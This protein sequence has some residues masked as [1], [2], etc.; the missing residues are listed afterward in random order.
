M[1]NPLVVQPDAAPSGFVNAGTGDNGWMTGISIAES[2][3]D[4]FN[5]IKDGNWVEGGLG[6][7][8]LVADA[9]S[10]A[11]D[12]FGTLLSSAASFLMEHMQPLKEALDWLAG[13]PPVIESYSATWNKV[14]EELGKI[15][16]DYQ[17]AVQQGTAQW[18][19]AAADAYR[20]A[21]GAQ[22]DALAGAASTAGSVGT[23]VGVMGM[24]V[25]FVREM[26]RDLIADLVAKLITWVL[27]AVFTLG[28]GTPVIVAQ[29]VTAISKWATRIGELIQ[30]L[31]KTIKKVSPLLGKI[32]E[33]FTK[34]MKVVGKLV[35]KVTG[36]DV[37]STKSIKPGGLFHRTDAPDLSPSGGRGTPSSPDSSSSTPDSSPTSSSSS[38]SPSSPDGSSPTSPSTGSSPSSP[39]SSSSPPPA[40]S[41]PSP[42]PSSNG[43]SPSSSPSPDGPGSPNAP[44]PGSPSSP[45]AGSPS[46]GGPAGGPPPGG[47]SAPSANGPGSTPDAPA[48]PR[49]TGQTSQAGVT[50]P[51]APTQHAPSAPRDGGP[52]AGSPTTAQQGPTGGPAGTPG[53]GAPG[54]PPAAGGARPGAGGGWTGT[55]GSRGD[56]GSGMPS[57]RTPDVSPSPAR[58]SAPSQPGFGPSGSPN[59][60]SAPHSPNAP[61]GGPSGPGAPHSPSGPSAPNAPHGGPGAPHGPGGGAPHSPDGP[62]GP[63]TTSPAGR[64]DAPTRPQ[65]TTSPTHADGPSAPHTSPNAPNAPG[66]PHVPQQPGFTPSPGG[67]GAPHAGGPGS[68]APGGHGP[69]GRPDAPGHRPDG[70]GSRPDGRPDASRPRTDAPGGHPGGPSRPDPVHH[71]PDADGAR[72][73]GAESPTTHPGQR[74]DAPGQPHHRPDGPDADGRTDGDTPNSPNAHA[75]ER[76][77]PEQAHERHAERTPAGVS[78]HGGDPDM[79][80]LPHRVPDDPRFFTADVH[81]TPDGRAR[82]GGH[83]YTPAEY[84]DMLRRSGYDGS[85]PVRLIGCDA[86]GNDF[87][88]QLS[89]H[90]D[91]PVVAPNRPAWTD[92][93]GRVFASDA[94]IGPDGTRSP[95][96]P[97][98]GEWETHHPDGSRT[99]AGEDGYAPGSDRNTDGDG[100]RDRGDSDGQENSD[101]PENQ[102]APRRPDPEHTPIPKDRVIRPDD[103]TYNDR[104]VEYDRPTHQPVDPDNP[105]APPRP[106]NRN[107]EIYAPHRDRETVPDGNTQPD[108]LQPVEAPDTVPAPLRD[109]QP[110]RPWTEYPVRNENGTRTTFI[111]DGDGKVKWVEATPGRQDMSIDGKG[112]WSGFNPDLSHPLLPDVQYQV[113]NTHNPDKVLSFHTNEHGQTDAMTG[114]VEAKGQN[115]DYRDDDSGKGAQQRAYQEGEAAYPSNPP[116]R[117]LTPQELENSRVKWAGGHLLANELGGLGEY[118]NMHPQMAASN[119]GNIRDGWVH[120]ASW[121]E[122]ENYLVEFAS[123]EHQDV[124]NYQVRATRGADGVPDE[125]TMRWQEVTYEVDANGKPKLDADGNKIVENVVTKERVFPNRPEVNYGPTNRYAKR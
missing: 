95:R 20:A 47:P 72:P 4:T 19:G 66:S 8:G 59:A 10:M 60:P 38:P 26:V 49:N 41:G 78:H 91:A 99:R 105:D 73:R 45:S 36:L 14:S 121:R 89:R 30:K 53:A 33:V 3:M 43:P 50:T 122:K 58:P 6:M 65:S 31:I 40:P 54:S 93:S 120:A 111:T 42:S 77:T 71:R 103:P 82:I 118:L 44:A 22:G 64:T 11:I 113:P 23:V 98:N 55:P 7:V 1:S 92:S 68:H 96:I 35:G 75:D 102:D 117:E 109:H 115:T 25:G 112:K 87:A 57:Q 79:G 18:E 67:P 63:G 100:A 90:L 9:A 76:P 5:G 29:A 80:D 94:E 34:I 39:P 28:F 81:V 2:A 70:P 83:H 84:A 114:E 106:L 56:L 86:G 69:G 37:I 125:V 52:S 116:D 46:S 123:K 24:V 108:R 17:Q 107:E 16:Q 119:S 124:Q 48:V 13:D 85:R 15:A 97:P 74:P 88:Q 101:A 32:V 110:L 27:E 51:E 104:F 62:H 21:A 61:H 12:P